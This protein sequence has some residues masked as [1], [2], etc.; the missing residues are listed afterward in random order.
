MPPDMSPAAQACWNTVVSECQFSG[1]LARV[2]GKALRLLAESWAL[3]LD[4]QDSIQKHGIVITEPTAH[5][6]NRVKANPAC[7]VRS[8][9]WKEVQT[10]LSKFGLTPADRTG[11][12]TGKNP[13]ESD[14]RDDVR[15]ILRIGG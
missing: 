7:A 8:K 15:K 9:A 1:V 3:Y 4:A 5:G 6:G 11:L 12:K 14:K 10:I 13:G 2:D